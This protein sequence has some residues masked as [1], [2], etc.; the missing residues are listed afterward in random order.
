M[1]SI[2]R[3]LLFEAIK[4]LKTDGILVYS[5]CSIAPEENEFVIND[6]LERFP[7]EL[8]EI[9]I[10]I[11]SPGFVNIFEKELHPTLKNSIR[12]FPHKDQMEGF[13]ICKLKKMEENQ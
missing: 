8:K 11:G 3:Q 4:Y 1:S 5:T 12:L 13:F 7:I 6:A 10:S 2:Q 9:K